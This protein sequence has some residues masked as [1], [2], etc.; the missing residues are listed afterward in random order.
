MKKIY[1]IPKM[2]VVLNGEFCQDTPIIEGPSESGGEVVPT[3]NVSNTFD[4][5][6]MMKDVST[7]TS[8]WDE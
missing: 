1:Q 7:P 3:G 5:N 8:L 6:E 2:E 4:D